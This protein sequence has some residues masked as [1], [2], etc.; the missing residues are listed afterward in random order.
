MPKTLKPKPLP[1]MTEARYNQWATQDAPIHVTHF[2]RV[3]AALEYERQRADEAEAAEKNL[4][5]L[6]KDRH[7]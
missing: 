5:A 3:L 2:R 4:R 1:P 6:M 7:G